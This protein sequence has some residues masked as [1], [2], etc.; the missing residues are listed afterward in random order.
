MDRAG[1]GTLESVE[2]SDL[3]SAPTEELANA[4][5]VAGMLSGRWT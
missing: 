4:C 1:M 3:R 2:W 5:C